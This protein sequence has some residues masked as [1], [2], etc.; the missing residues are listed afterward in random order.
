MIAY[1]EDRDIVSDKDGKQLFSI[2]ELDSGNV[3]KSKVVTGYFDTCQQTIS[4]K[5]GQLLNGFIK[6]VSLVPQDPLPADGRFKESVFHA[7]DDKGND[8]AAEVVVVGKITGT[9]SAS[10]TATI[11]RTDKDGNPLYWPPDHDGT[12][13]VN[14][15][16]GNPV[17][18]KT[19]GDQKLQ[20]LGTIQCDLNLDPNNAQGANYTLKR[21]GML[22]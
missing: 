17:T 16:D 2:D 12:A 18:V 22:D 6:G 1:Y 15:K 10:V 3:F 7:T 4:G 8:L 14:D 19:V 21:D 5:D 9:D 11:I 13:V 20:I